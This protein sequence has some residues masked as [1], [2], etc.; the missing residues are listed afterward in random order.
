MREDSRRAEEMRKRCNCA[1]CVEARR[2]ARIALADP[3]RP[4]VLA[5]VVPV[6][7]DG[8]DELFC[9]YNKYDNING[10]IKTSFFRN[11][12]FDFLEERYKMDSYKYL[13]SL[14]PYEAETE[15]ELMRL[16]DVHI[17]L[18]GDILQKIDRTSMTSSLEV[19]IVIFSIYNYFTCTFFKP[20]SSN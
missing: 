3:R 11:K 12:N 10:D 18:E 14:L 6:G 19:V 7:G 17:F 8:A 20:N 1:S 4:G 16:L 5:A 13:L 9:G 2:E 15:K